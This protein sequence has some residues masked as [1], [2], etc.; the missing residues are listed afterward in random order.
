MTDDDLRNALVTLAEGL[1]GWLKGEAERES[2]AG[3]IASRERFLLEL[4]TLRQVETPEPYQQDRLR[5]LEGGA[6]FDRK[7]LAE[8]QEIQRQHDEVTGRLREA[9]RTISRF[10]R[11]HGINAEP[12]TRLLLCREV[13]RLRD[14]LVV[15]RQVEVEIPPLPP[16]PEPTLSLWQGGFC[17]HGKKHDLSGKPLGVLKSLLVAPGHAR[18]ASDLLKDAWYSSDKHS[19]ST[20]Q[21]VKDAVKTLRAELRAAYSQAKGVELKEDP[22]RCVGKG[23][24]LAWELRL[25]LLA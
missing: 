22:V 8:H 17:L 11:R 3:E 18:T 24:D 12:L 19:P 10:A 7:Q 16:P 13:D 4:K 20:D 6:D 1:P 9:E 21:N 14:V 23:P 5:L 2:V 15:L 25:D